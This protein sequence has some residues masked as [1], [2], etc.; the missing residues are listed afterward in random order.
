MPR[1]NREILTPAE[2]KKREKYIAEQKKRDKQIR[3]QEHYARKQKRLFY[4]E[5]AVLCK[6]YGCYIGSLSGENI[7]KVWQGEEIYTLKS[8]LSG[9]IRSF[10]WANR[11]TFRP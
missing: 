9:L 2:Q 4:D 6:K 10:R 3:R 7:H 5:Y 11:P 8:H 1:R